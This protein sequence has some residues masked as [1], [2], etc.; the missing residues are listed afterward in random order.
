MEERGIFKDNKAEEAATPDSKKR[1]R[2]GQYV[3]GTQ[4]ILS[5]LHI[6]SGTPFTGDFPASKRG[7]DLG[8]S[9]YRG[10]HLTPRNFTVN[11]GEDISQKICFLALQ[12]H[13]IVINSGSCR[14]TG[15][16][17]SCAGYGI[18]LSS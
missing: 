18:Q 5:S 17:R 12:F 4:A 16:C 8:I 2:T 13:A 3:S 7:R 6:L 1:D 14:S 10:S 9:S 11:S 15:S